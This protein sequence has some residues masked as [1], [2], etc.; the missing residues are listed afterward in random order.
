MYV[1]LASR[2]RTD[3]SSRIYTAASSSQRWNSVSTPS[4][5]SAFLDQRTDRLSPEVLLAVVVA[6]FT[7]DLTEKPIVWN[8]AG[9]RYPTVGWESNKAEMPMNVRLY[10][11][12]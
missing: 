5:P 7:F 1:P 9:V 8:V 6:N 10:G 11:P 12:H 3:Y 4:Y 2:V